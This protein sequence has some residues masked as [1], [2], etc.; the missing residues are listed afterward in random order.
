MLK[1]IEGTDDIFYIG[2]DDKDMRLF[3]NQYNTPEGISYNSYLIRDD[4]CVVMDTADERVKDEWINNLEEALDGRSPDYLVVS[5]MEPDHSACVTVFTEKYP[6]AKL[7]VNAKTLTFLKQFFDEDFTDRSLIVKEG[8]VFETGHHSLSFIMAPMVHWPEVMVAYD[9]ADKILFSADAFGTFGVLN[10][11]IND[12]GDDWA[13]EAS[14]YYINIV[15]KYGTPVSNLLKKVET[16]GL[17]IKMIC[18][19]HGPVLDSDTDKYI[20]YYKKWSAYESDLEGTFIVHASL[21]GNTA[22]I[23][24]KFGDM[25]EAE[26]ERIAYS[27]LTVDD[28]PAAVAKAFRFGKIVLMSSTYEGDI[29]PV[30]NDFLYR[31]TLKGCM[32]KR[33]G[34]VENFS[35]GAVA[36]KKM[37]EMVEAMKGMEIVEPLVSV[38]TRLT[39]DTEDG[40]RE[41]AE[42]ILINN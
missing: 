16:Q 1:L 11:N 39:P 15:G 27:D 41:L 21:H 22:A 13:R 18:A 24:K 14:R 8:D 20:E 38:K 26:G 40:L 42:R 34:I 17:D 4:K 33:I 23:A 25:L 2:A 29:M 30:M 9:S 36:G 35:W 31:L 32:N 12:P 5:H 3:E 37:R 10:G 19:L 28:V 7:I 6:E